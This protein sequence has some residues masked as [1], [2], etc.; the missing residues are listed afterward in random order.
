M[1]IS[2]LIPSPSRPSSPLFLTQ[3]NFYSMVS[4]DHCLEYTLKFLVLC[5]FPKTPS[6]AESTCS[7]LAPEKL[8]IVGKPRWLVLFYIHDLNLTP[9][10]PGNSCL[11]LAGSLRKHLTLPDNHSISLDHNY[12]CQQMTLL[13][14]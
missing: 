6:L 12:F 11:R 5:S 14:V 8:N 2:K 7:A 10:T 4:H 1:T 9:N 3:L 13:A